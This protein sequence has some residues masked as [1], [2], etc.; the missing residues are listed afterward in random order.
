MNAGQLGGEA[1]L[2]RTGDKPLASSEARSPRFPQGVW[3]GLAPLRMYVE[4][5]RRGAG[6]HV[7]M[8]SSS[9]AKAAAKV[10]CVA[11]LA[12]ALALPGL[13]Q[14]PTRAEPANPEEARKRLEAEKSRLEA[15]KKRSKELQASA[16]KIRR[17]IEGIAAHLV[18]TGKQIQASEARLSV[19]ESKQGELEKQEQQLRGSLAKRHKAL[20]ALLAT[21][22]RM[23][24]NP[25]PVMVTRREDALTM[26]RSAML[27]APA[28]P[29]LQ[30][31]AAELSKEL[32]ELSQVIQ[33]SRAESER[34]RA[35]KAQHDKVRVRLAALQDDKRRA[36]VRYQTE[37][38]SVRQ[39]VARIAGS[40]REVS[41]LLSKLDREFQERA[42]ST[43]DT[44]KDVAA[45]LTPS[46]KVVSLGRIRPQIPF[47]QARGML[48][49]PAQ[50]IRAVSFGQR[51]GHG[52]PSKNI[53]IRTRF[54]A[55]VVSPCDGLVV[56]AGEFRTYGQLLIISPGGGYHVVLIGLAQIDV[57]VGQSVL[58]GEPVGA[59]ASDATAQDNRGPVLYVEFQK[60]RRPI[61]PD[62]W[63]SDTSRKVQG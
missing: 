61:D 21:L 57:Q 53:G 35:E 39:E 24:R 4:A 5:V 14:S 33:S 47:A 22:Q 36:G 59:M 49:L 38:N 58:M 9:F 8:S 17:E 56:Y 25:P 50:G 3:I 28:I 45:T 43:A 54:G 7:G 19:I 42:P 18:K 55:T 13:A 30:K 46:Q 48:Q 37:L 62:P 34:L 63:W 6:R 41:D 12:V 29:K 20:S 26:V 1:A 11:A 40:V 16:D 10:A 27:L 2:G 23:G 52:S 60:D 32:S 44:S 51:T 31:Q 15:E